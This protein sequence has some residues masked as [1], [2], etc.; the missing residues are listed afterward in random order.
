[1]PIL[2]SSGI[3]ALDKQASSVPLSQDAFEEG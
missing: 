2:P 1:M 3:E